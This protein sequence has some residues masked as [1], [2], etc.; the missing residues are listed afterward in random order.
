MKEETDDDDDDNDDYR[1]NRMRVGYQ[2]LRWSAEYKYSDMT[3]PAII[4]MMIY[5]YILQS[6]YLNSITVRVVTEKGTINLI[7]F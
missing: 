5:M 2:R 4:T 3:T 7:V 1:I 6:H